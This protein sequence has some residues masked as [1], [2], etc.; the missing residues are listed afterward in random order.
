[1]LSS[2][3]LKSLAIRKA[4]KQHAG[5]MFLDQEIVRELDLAGFAI[6]PKEP[7]TEIAAAMWIA[8]NEHEEEGRM[9]AA[10]RAAIAAAEK[11]EGG[12]AT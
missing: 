4:L 2:D 8:W 11:T 6:V 7:T 1:M 10:Y 3:V 5:D 9:R 12:E